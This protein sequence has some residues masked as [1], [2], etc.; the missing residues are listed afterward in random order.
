V[1]PEGGIRRVH[2]A[3]YTDIQT[4]MKWNKVAHFQKG[5]SDKVYI[6][7]V[8]RV[9]N[10]FEV[11]GK[12]GRRGKRLTQQSKGVFQSD[13]VAARVMCDQFHEKIRKGYVDVTSGMY[14]SGAVS[15]KS[16]Y[17]A[18]YLSDPTKPFNA[19]AAL[20]QKIP[21]SQAKKMLGVQDKNEGSDFAD[22]MVCVDNEGMEDDFDKD[23]SYVVEKGP[24]KDGF[25]V[26]RNKFGH[27][28]RVFKSRFDE[29]VELVES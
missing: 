21:I 10:G 29:M 18:Q 11:I 4:L 8:H 16:L 12:W 2:M 24:D 13:R 17:I 25:I 26:V 22:E 7:S 5:S 20:T 27:S 9:V 23:V 1:L 28:K 15:F 14:S 3:A 6:V 19:S